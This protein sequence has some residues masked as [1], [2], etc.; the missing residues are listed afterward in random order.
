MVLPPRQT[1]P[2]KQSSRWRS[3]AHCTFVRGYQCA[4][5]GCVGLPIEAAHVRFG[6]GAGMG[7]KPSDWRVTPLCSEHHRQQHTA[8]EPS[9][10]QAYQA[11]T[12]QDVEAL[13]D[14]LCNASPKAAE[15]RKVR[16]G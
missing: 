5:P 8:G 10:W 11:T 6:S 4:V 14:A 1:K 16:N 12:G 9:F 15:I 7:Q 2:V 13:I 3:Q